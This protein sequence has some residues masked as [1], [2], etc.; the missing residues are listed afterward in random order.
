[1]IHIYEGVN[2]IHSTKR[3]TI[4]VKGIIGLLS[5]FV[6]G[7]WIGS[8][9]VEPKEVEVVKM[10]D[11][12]VYVTKPDKEFN[13]ENFKELIVELNIRFPHIV[14]AQAIEETGYFTSTIFRENNNLFGMK[15]PVIRATTAVG[16]HRGHAHYSNWMNSVKDYALWQSSMA[17][18]INSEEEYLLMLDKIYAENPNYINNLK[19]IIKSDEL[20]AY[21]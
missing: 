11:N 10:V 6:V 19:N 17:R 9:T 12:V 5:I 2:P 13:P 21:F 18:G 7:I 20:L 3:L 16:T 8:V 4:I 14:Y 1:M 15:E